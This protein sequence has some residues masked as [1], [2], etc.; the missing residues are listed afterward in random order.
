MNQGLSD[1]FSAQIKKCKISSGLKSAINSSLESIN[2]KQKLKFSQ[3]VFK[4]SSIHD[5]V[6]NMQSRK[7]NTIEEEIIKK[8]LKNAEKVKSELESKLLYVSQ[9]IG[10]LQT[11]N[12]CSTVKQKSSMQKSS[13]KQQELLYADEIKRF[14]ELRK[15]SEHFLRLQSEK[16]L[17]KAKKLEEDEMKIQQDKQALREKQRQEELE[18]FRIKWDQ[19]S[20]EI[21][22]IKKSSQASSPN[23]LEQKPLFIKLEENFKIYCE[24]PAYLKRKEELKKRSIYFSPMHLADLKKHEDWYNSIKESNTQKFQKKL[25]SQ[26]IDSQIRSISVKESVWALKLQ[27]EQQKQ[28]KEKQQKIDQKKKLLEKKIKYSELVKE[29]FPISSNSNRSLVYSECKS[30]KSK[31]IK[32]KARTENESCETKLWKPH[33]FAPN[34]MVPQ[35]KTPKEPKAVWYLEEKRRE[36]KDEGVNEVKKL[37]E[38]VENHLGKGSLTSRD[39]KKVQITANRLDEL[40][41]KKELLVGRGDSVR[42]IEKTADADKI[43]ISAIRAKMHLLENL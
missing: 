32:S 4:K 18:K 23:F 37:E 40:A 17:K 16:I 25:N 29:I 42:D 35:Q 1:Y 38:F 3:K 30:E 31:G 14:A 19:K 33:K 10:E 24:M 8:Q 9:S 15:K 22:L 26:A 7:P 13:I 27:E 2:N 21:E 20:K 43:L 11:L 41:R 34:P 6:M 39:K 12:Q 5:L 28:D 36:K